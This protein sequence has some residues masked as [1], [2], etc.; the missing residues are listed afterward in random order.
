M[1]CSCVANGTLLLVLLGAG[2]ASAQGPTGVAIDLSYPFNEETVYWPTASPFELTVEAAG[3]TEAGYWYAANSF[4]AAEHGGTHLDAP[5]HFAEGKRTAAEIPLDDLMGP[6]VVVDVSSAA[7]DD[8]DYLVDITAMEEWEREHGAIPG[9]AI[10]LL[11]TGWG[12]RWPDRSSYLGTA[13]LGPEAVADLHFPGLGPDAAAWLVDE[14]RVRAVGIDTASIDRGQSTQFRAHRVLAEANVPIFENVANL[15][16]LPATG[17]W[18]VALPMQIERG[19]GGPLRA[20]AFVPDSG[21]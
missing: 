5:I 21:K 1:K 2:Q 4:S 18:V 13:E 12:G 20:V 15:D 8:A 10:V 14:R 6:A 3:Q 16:R 19:T 9:R 7:A 11:K 17:A